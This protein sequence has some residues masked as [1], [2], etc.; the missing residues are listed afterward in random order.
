MPFQHEDRIRY[1]QFESLTDHG[2][3][4][5]IFTRQGGLSPEPWASLNVGGLIG[6]DPERVYENRVLSFQALGRDPDSVYDVWQVHGAEVICTWRNRPKGAA[7]IKADAILTDRPEI[8][9]FMRFADCVP[10][11]LFDPRCQVIGLVH[12]G[13]QGTVK[14]VVQAALRQMERE[15]GTRMS[16]LL[17][18]IGPSIGVDH[19]EIGPEVAHQVQEAFNAQANALLPQNN[20]S[21]YFDL[22]QANRLILESRGVDQVEVAGICTACH[23]EDWYSHRGEKGKTGRFGGLIALPDRE[24]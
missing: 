1:Y 5:G 13:W 19:Y 7:H 18:C 22:W 4:H 24:A 11:V 6:D 3:T 16:D 8:T 23:P 20:G 15:Y 12:A 2:V 21:I 17:A 10:V 14:G 9:L